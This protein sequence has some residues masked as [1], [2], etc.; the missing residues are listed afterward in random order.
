MSKRL[1][2]DLRKAITEPVENTVFIPIENNMYSSHATIIV[3]DGPY[4]G[5][6][7][8]I[9]IELPK[10]YPLDAPAAYVKSSFSHKFH[11][12]VHT[13]GSIC[14]DLTS[15]FKSY[16]GENKGGGWTSICSINSL[17]LQLGT[18]FSYDID[19]PVRMMPSNEDI[20]IMRVEQETFVCPECKYCYLD[21]KYT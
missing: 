8:H 3:P 14:C 13:A 19:L 10:T 16:F 6:P 11:E 7:I 12:H 15:N 9:H 18:F 1:Q 4:K 21:K 20:D 2:F 5:I 17:L